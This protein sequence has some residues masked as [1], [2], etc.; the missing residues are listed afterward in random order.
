[1]ANIKSPRNDGLTKEFYETFWEGLKKP[2]CDSITEA[3][4]RGELSHSQKQAVIKLIEKKDRDNTFVKSWR[5]TL[6]LNIDT[7]HV[8]KV[9]AEILKNVLPS[10]IS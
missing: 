9:L 6:L 8:S 10:L 1:M 7:K 3:S 2:L 4:H 5:P